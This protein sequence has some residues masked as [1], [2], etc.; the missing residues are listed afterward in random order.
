MTKVKYVV[1][2][3]KVDANF[4]LRLNDA[5]KLYQDVATKNVEELGCG[6]DKILEEYGYM[7]VVT[8]MYLEFYKA[9]KYLDEIYVSTYPYTVRGGFS[10][11]RQAE[12]DDKD[13][14]PLLKIS[15]SWILMDH[16]T[17]RMVLRPQIGMHEESHDGALPEPGKV[18]KEESSL[19]Y[20]RKVRYCDCDIN[21]HLNNVRYIDM[22]I[23]IFDVEFYKENMIETM[24]MN[25]E[26]E[27]KCGETIDIYVSDDKSYVE[28]RVG[29]S[30]VFQCKMTFKKI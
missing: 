6:M 7:W 1:D 11:M 14:K 8:R 21:N 15:S 24:L 22:I 20:S 25:Y 9:P 5:L 12:I 27:V 10:F 18:V 4:N 29:E 3:M 26:K 2:A 13:N 23:D 19:L 17:H 28:G 16:L 30:T